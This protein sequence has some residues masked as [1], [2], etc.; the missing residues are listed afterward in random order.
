LYNI[1]DFYPSTSNA[2]LHTA[3]E[4]AAEHATIIVTDRTVTFYAR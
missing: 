3:L 2:L 4:F 1:D